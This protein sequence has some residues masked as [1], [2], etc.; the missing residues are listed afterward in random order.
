MIERL[1][2]FLAMQW[3][4]AAVEVTRFPSGAIDIGVRLRGEAVVIQGKPDTGYG[5]AL[6]TDDEADGWMGF[7][8]SSPRRTKPSATCRTSWG[9]FRDDAADRCWC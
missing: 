2:E 3:P 6:L 5:I 1:L 4:Q 7:A 9:A 8:T